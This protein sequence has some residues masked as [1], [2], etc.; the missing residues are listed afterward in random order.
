MK[1]AKA[2]E[3]FCLAYS[4]ALK[5]ASALAAALPG[6]ARNPG[7]GDFFRH[8]SAMIEEFLSEF[9]ERQSARG[10]QQQPLSQ[11]RLEIRQAA[12]NGGFGHG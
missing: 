1:V 12:G 3:K 9:G 2:R 10:A 6:C 11:C 8:A 7:G 5:H 4:P